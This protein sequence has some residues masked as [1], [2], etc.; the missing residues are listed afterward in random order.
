ML[1]PEFAFSSPGPYALQWGP[2]SVRWYG[3]AI[4]IAVMAGL[5]VAQTLA[6]RRGLNP[7]SLNDL[8]L[9]LVAG[10]LPLARLYYV[11]FNWGVYR[12]R[13]WE[14]L[15]IW[16]GGIAI[17]GAI[18]GGVL[19]VLLFARIHKLA[20]WP[21]ADVLVPSLAL[22]QAIGRWGNFFNSEAYGAPTDLP[23]K[24]FIPMANRPDAYQSV[25]YFHPTFLYES[26]WNLGVF[27]LLLILFIRWPRL[28][29]GAI[30]CAYA[31]VYSIGRFWIEGLRLDSL[32]LGP[33]RVAQVVS[34]A[35]IIAGG[36]GLYWHYSGDSPPASPTDPSREA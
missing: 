29:P 28:K 22:G 19:A 30:A 33:L 18:L 15:A 20:F 7:D 35:L 32:T 4:A 1:L 34:I 21:L 25:E 14:I 12:E 36:I 6:P 9:W 11:A 23:W 26:L 10:A 27:S 2:L 8:L 24:L 16:R 13:P 31:I 5:F 17:H 3:I